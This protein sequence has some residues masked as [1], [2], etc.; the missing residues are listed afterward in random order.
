MSEINT[1]IS[2][3]GIDI[4]FE[5]EWTS[6]FNKGLEPNI[7]SFYDP[8]NHSLELLL[9]L[10]CID[11]HKRILLN[12]NTTKIFE[13]YLLDFPQLK[14]FDRSKID[15]IRSEIEAKI[16]LGADVDLFKLSKEY[17]IDINYILDLKP[18]DKTE[19]K[20]KQFDLIKK[21]GQG[22]YGI[23]YLAKD[24]I[25]SKPIDVALKVLV[26]GSSETL[27]RFKEEAS[28][29]AQLRHPNII[30]IYRYGMF[31]N[32]NFYTM[33]YCKETLADLVKIKPL[34]FRKAA[35]IISQVAKGI[36]AAHN[37][38]IIHRDIKPEN[39]L[40][41][42]DGTPKVADFGLAKDLTS[43]QNLT[44][45]GNLIGTR[46]FIAPEQLL[47]EKIYFESDVYSLGAT[48]YKIISGKYP[49]PVEPDENLKQL[50]E[51][52]TKTEPKLLRKLVPDVPK[53]LNN[54][55]HKALNRN[56]SSRYKNG[57]ELAADLDR[58]L[59]GKPVIARNIGY[60]EKLGRWIKT[61]P[62]LF[63]FFTS[64]FLFL[65]FLGIQNQKINLTAN[66]LMDALEES[67]LNKKLA[68][69]KS[70]EA[71]RFINV[72]NAE[73]RE[74][75]KQSE[76]AQNLSEFI[77]YPKIVMNLE[78]NEFKK[79]I[80]QLGSIPFSK[81]DWEHDFLFSII[82]RGKSELL[83][84]DEKIKNVRL[85]AN[86][87][88]IFI[89][90]KSKI[91]I[92]ETSPSNIFK[93]TNIHTPE[94]VIHVI[95]SNLHDEI[96]VCTNTSRIAKINNNQLVFLDII[97]KDFITSGCINHLKNEAILG[98][99]NGK[100]II[101][102][103]NKGTIINE[104]FAHQKEIVFLEFIP[105]SDQLISCEKNGL[106]KIWNIGMN[107]K[108]ILKKTIETKK[109]LISI[110][111]NPNSKFLTFL[112]DAS[113]LQTI[114][115]ESGKDVWNIK[116]KSS[117]LFKISISKDGR[118]I[119]G[120]KSNGFLIYDMY[121][122]HEIKFIPADLGLTNFDLSKD[123][124]FILGGESDLFLWDMEQNIELAS[125]QLP[126]ENKCNV[127]FFDNHNYIIFN[128]SEDFKNFSLNYFSLNNN[129]N[130][131]S[132][133]WDSRLIPTENQT[134]K[135]VQYIFS[136]IFKTSILVSKT[137]KSKIIEIPNS[138]RNLQL[139]GQTSISINEKKSPTE[140]VSLNLHDCPMSSIH[141]SPDGKTLLIFFEDGW[142]KLYRINYQ[143]H[144]YVGPDL[145]GDEREKLFKP[146]YEN[147]KVFEST[148]NIN[149]TGNIFLM[150]NS[151]KQ[152]ANKM[153]FNLERCNDLKL[154]NDFK[155]LK[156]AERENDF[157]GINFYQNK[158]QSL[159]KFSK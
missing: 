81:R 149:S 108:P 52:V 87:Q 85:F 93:K 104:F 53:D 9:Q 79:A 6:F 123:G 44:L 89:Q 82:N 71:E 132:V 88:K 31:K 97:F 136:I 72:A 103:L 19:N 63:T 47:G 122:G 109:N 32:H 135:N 27:Q 56:I 159:G 91:T 113:N 86:D 50:I 126:I 92:Y 75:L 80:D 18:S 1:N 24:F 83:K 133:L 141:L 101:V 143:M 96:L 46:G 90:D 112:D 144:Y 34:P 37:Q 98:L 84:H 5:H 76:I 67:E 17:T 131:Y 13:D 158:L 64:I 30:Q 20:N 138:N 58:F 55:I 36:G 154:Y 73:K 26:N 106:I 150:D 43:E 107:P 65:I 62:L 51:K 151:L 100:L 38:K 29:I 14:K 116:N 35:E 140:I 66:K 157:F 145:E 78:R 153:P 99:H 54:I 15:L 57:N 114:D 127:L 120:A 137:W 147:G 60:F 49:F 21:L 45:T 95:S 3:E 28:K 118:K 130:N 42:F 148:E 134:I 115:L 128:Y 124:N 2:F 129:S 61:N 40:M 74:A 139:E 7:A 94:K 152:T 70:E 102:D 156:L 125:I 155:N 110:S 48:L 16:T 33:E 39:I 117:E 105:Y 10:C 41:S 68:E 23:V 11:L 59:E 25:F 119:I 77:K 12:T 69:E 146:R 111:G 121:D 8:E 4:A 22:A 142:M